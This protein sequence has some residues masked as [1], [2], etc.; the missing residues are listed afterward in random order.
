MGRSGP[1]PMSDEVPRLKGNPGH[2]RLSSPERIPTAAEVMSAITGESPL[3]F[4]ERHARSGGDPVT[5]A[6]SEKKSQR[7][8]GGARTMDQ[9]SALYDGENDVDVDRGAARVHAPDF[10]PWLRCPSPTSRGCYE[11]A[12]LLHPARPARPRPR[13]LWRKSRCRIA[14]AIVSPGAS[15]L[16]FIPSF[17]E[18]NSRNVRRTRS[19]QLMA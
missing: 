9:R 7:R 3:G 18:R 4:L 5:T 2:R 10:G 13:R 19:L 8:C 6:L 16:C 14:S 1:R 12:R 15:S 17:T 11:P